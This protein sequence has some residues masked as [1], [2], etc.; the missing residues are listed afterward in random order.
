MST[1]FSMMISNQNLQNQKEVTVIK[2]GPN[3]LQRP[4]AMAEKI[5][6]ESVK[7]ERRAIQINSWVLSEK[8]SLL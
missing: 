1:L 2:E 6:G 3:Q 5:T 8:M 7:V 4:K